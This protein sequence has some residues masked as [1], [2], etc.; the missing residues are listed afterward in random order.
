M[1]TADY[2]E[3]LQNDLTIL[4]TSLDLDEGTNFTDIAEM[5]Q[6]GEITKGG[7]TTINTISDLNNVVTSYNNK[8]TTM[9]NNYSAYSQ[10]S[11]TIYTPNTNCR[12]FMIQ[13]RSGGKYRIV[14]SAMGYYVCLYSND[15]QSFCNFVNNNS[16]GYYGLNSYSFQLNRIKQA[17][18]ETAYYSNE[19]SSLE[20]LITAIQQPILS[21]N[22]SYTVYYNGFSYTGVLDN[23]WPCPITNIPVFYSDMNFPYE[24]GKV[25]SH[26]LTISV[27][28]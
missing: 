5:A 27:A 7:G 28:S 6:G 8:L 26:N 10:N 18:S 2:L 9:V 22:I 1:T 25:L 4:K 17:Y 13:K 14:W 12:N 15:T 21:G 11:M 24:N 3:S 20:A 23:D 19:F 16:A